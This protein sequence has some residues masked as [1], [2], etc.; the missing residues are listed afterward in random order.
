MESKVLV[1]YGPKYNKN[2][3]IDNFNRF[4]VSVCKSLVFFHA[5]KG[6]DYCVKYKVWKDKFWAVW[7]AKV[8]AGD[9]ALSSIFKKFSNCLLNIEVNEFDTLC[10]FVYE[11]Y[12]LTKQA[13]FKT[14]RTDHLISMPNVRLRMLV[15]SQSGILQNIKRACI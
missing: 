4:D 3:I 12:G 7:L 9:T 1:V 2:D 6:C 14:R 10:N 11:G 5:F 8:K 15:P 13:R